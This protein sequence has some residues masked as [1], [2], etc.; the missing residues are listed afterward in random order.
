YIPGVFQDIRGSKET[1]LLSKVYG[2]FFVCMYLSECWGSQ[3]KWAN[4]WAYA[5]GGGNVV[6]P[7]L[8]SG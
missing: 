8:V 2:F 6:G 3:R 4:Q 5:A 7:F 1:V